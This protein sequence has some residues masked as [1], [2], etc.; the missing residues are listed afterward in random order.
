MDEFILKI[1][2]KE[3]DSYT[4]LYFQGHLITFYPFGHGFVRRT[5]LENETDEEF[6]KYRKHFSEKTILILQKIHVTYEKLKKVSDQLKD[7]VQKTPGIRIRVGDGSY[8][9]DV[10]ALSASDQEYWKELSKNNPKS[11]IP[12]IQFDTIVNSDVVKEDIQEGL[13]SLYTQKPHNSKEINELLKNFTAD[14]EFVRKII[15]KV[16]MYDLE[17][18]SELGFREWQSTDKLF[19]TTAK[20]IALEKDD[21]VLEKQD[22]KRTTIGLNVLRKTDQ[23]Y[24]KTLLESPTKK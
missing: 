17:K 24:V 15:R 5:K 12:F 22:G 3:A 10:S 8:D 13:I 4:A 18:I 20:F 7:F 19:K 2:D 9:Y 6:I 1:L 14:K 21:V 11:N 16:P 23:D